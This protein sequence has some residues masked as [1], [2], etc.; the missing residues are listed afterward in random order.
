MLEEA[1]MGSNEALN[2]RENP[3]NY[4]Q[5]TDQPVTAETYTTRYGREV[6]PP[7]YYY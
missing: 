7:S 2:S 3:K 4:T 5:E 1:T 6:K